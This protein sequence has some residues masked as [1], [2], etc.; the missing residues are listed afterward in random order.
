MYWAVAGRPGRETEFPRRD[1]LTFDAW[2]ATLDS[3]AREL[4]ESRIRKQYAI[5]CRD[6][7]GSAKELLER[8]FHTP[9]DVISR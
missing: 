2:W 9:G 8:Y 3:T 7:E 5:D 6:D 4:E 1:P